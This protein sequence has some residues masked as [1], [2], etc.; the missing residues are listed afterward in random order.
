MQFHLLILDTEAQ[1]DKIT[2]KTTQ[3]ERSTARRARWS[4]A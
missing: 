3:L 4:D 2:A 1:Q